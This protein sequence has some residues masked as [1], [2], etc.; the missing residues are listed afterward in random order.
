MTNIYNLYKE[1]L[2]RHKR[3][4]KCNFMKITTQ[5]QCTCWFKPYQ[6]QWIAEIKNCPRNK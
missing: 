4:R 2:K 1:A 6:G 5:K 3:C